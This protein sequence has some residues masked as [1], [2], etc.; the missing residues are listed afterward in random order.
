MPH[1]EPR[2][3]HDWDMT[4][5]TSRYLMFSNDIMAN[6]LNSTT[7]HDENDVGSTA[8]AKTDGNSWNMLA[9]CSLEIYIIPYHAALPWN[10][11][12][13]GNSA[14]PY[15]HTCSNFLDPISRVGILSAYKRSLTEFRMFCS[16]NDNECRAWSLFEH[17]LRSIVPEIDSDACWYVWVCCYWY[18]YI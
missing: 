2:Q 6:K 3:E 11:P 15:I 1:K 5:P 12:V 14:D 9:A 10:T 8:G 13:L 16:G 7:G 4:F 18:V 17:H